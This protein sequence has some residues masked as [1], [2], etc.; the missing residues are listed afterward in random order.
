MINFEG[1]I[2]PIKT[3]RAKFPLFEMRN[4]MFLQLGSL[5]I[6]G[7]AKTKCETMDVKQL[8]F[9][10]D[11]FVLVESWLEKSDVCPS[12]PSY[13]PFRSDRKKTPESQT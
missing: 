4:N 1:L 11:I 10:Y 6:Q 12:I 5:N 9:K 13:T 3:E 8:I 2:W 7:S